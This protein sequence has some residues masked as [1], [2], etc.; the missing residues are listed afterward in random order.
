MSHGDLVYC[1]GK[2][3]RAHMVF[4]VWGDPRQIVKK[5]YT[6]SLIKVQWDGFLKQNANT[7]AYSGR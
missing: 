5:Y 1:A 3:K 4:L 6:P 2:L 7:G